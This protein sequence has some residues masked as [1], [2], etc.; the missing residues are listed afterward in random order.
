[1]VIITM[2]TAGSPRE[3]T[4]REIPAQNIVNLQEIVSTTIKGDNCDDNKIPTPFPTKNV[5]I[6][7]TKI[8]FDWFYEERHWK[9]TI[10]TVVSE[11]SCH[12]LN[13][14]KDLVFLS[15]FG[16]QNL[17]NGPQTSSEGILSTWLIQIDPSL[18]TT[19]YMSTRVLQL[20]YHV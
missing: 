7:Q 19:S 6:I 10:K 20:G 9:K 14:L 18:V 15:Y 17:C 4:C 1:M 12:Y 2:I 8:S 5:K 13:R 3:F 11:Q 16:T